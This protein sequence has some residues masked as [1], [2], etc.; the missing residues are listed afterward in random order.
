MSLSCL[1]PPRTPRDHMG[2]HCDA[3]TSL[4]LLLPPSWPPVAMRAPWRA[5]LPANKR[6][7]QSQ[8]SSSARVGACRHPVPEEAMLR[9][10]PPAPFGGSAP[11]PPQHTTRVA[12]VIVVG[13]SALASAAAYSLARRGKKVCGAGRGGRS[14]R[15]V[16]SKYGSKHR[17]RR[18]RVCTARPSA[19]QQV[20][21]VREMGVQP[22]GAAPAREAL[23]PVLLPSTSA[24]LT[25]MGNESLSYL[26]GLEMQTGTPLL[27]RCGSLDVA[28]TRPGSRQ[29]Q[30]SRAAMSDLLVA[31]GNVSREADLQAKAVLPADLITPL[32]MLR[33]RDDA[34]GLLQVGRLA[35][36]GLRVA[37][38]GISAFGHRV[39]PAAGQW[40]RARSG[41]R[42][43]GPGRVLKGP[44]P[45]YGGWLGGPCAGGRRR[46]ERRAGGARAAH[47]G[48]A[49]GRGGAGRLGAARCAWRSGFVERDR[50]IGGISRVGGPLLHSRMRLASCSVA[51]RLTRA[52]WRAR[53]KARRASWCAP[54]AARRV[55]GHWQHVPRGGV[56]PPAARRGDGARGGA[57]GRARRT[58]REARDVRGSPHAGRHSCR[59]IM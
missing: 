59:A 6:E 9:G 26:L 36:V 53:R 1:F 51:L 19:H 52:L 43:G 57:G 45:S 21:H 47:A 22:P 37:G 2:M 38:S 27:Q 17:V 48:R 14:Q 29:Q 32:P 15:R 44:G 3:V 39:A 25:S 10:R 23:R 31:L 11:A 5:T 4:V 8:P 54:A 58:G 46:G 18:S 16:L 56:L 7:I 24:L 30:R 35:A 12:D 20:A 28:A 49:G 13:D 34:S 40:P 33:L 50:L 41:G 42:G 55:A